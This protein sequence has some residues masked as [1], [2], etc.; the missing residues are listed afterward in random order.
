MNSLEIFLAITS[1]VFF[2]TSL[3][4]FYL[5]FKTKISLN[6]AELVSTQN[7]ELKETF[8]NLANDVL[9]GNSERFLQLAKSTLEKETALSQSELSKKQVEFQRT[10]EPI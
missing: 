7:E 2:T 4:L 9:T 5:Y 10:V 8:K 6:K 1:I 3:T